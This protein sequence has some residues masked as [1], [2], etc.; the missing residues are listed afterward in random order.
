MSG[1]H[2]QRRV[3]TAVG[4]LALLAWVAV[5]FVPAWLSSERQVDDGRR[6]AGGRLGYESRY[7]AGWLTS[8]YRQHGELPS[9][10]PPNRAA[11][12]DAVLIELCPQQPGDLVH[13]EADWALCHQDRSV[14]ALALELEHVVGIDPPEKV[15][16]FPN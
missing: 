3:W 13:R 11:S 1:A 8:Y 10:L 2:S 6:R 4:A 12:G 16:L 7:D 9:S 5:D 15:E 14:R